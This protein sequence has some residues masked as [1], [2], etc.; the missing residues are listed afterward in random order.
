MRAL[1]PPMPCLIL[2][3]SVAA[4]A[5]PDAAAR[6]A[7]L[8]ERYSA[9]L[10]IVDHETD[11]KIYIPQIEPAS[12]LVISGC[13][14]R[15]EIT[16]YSNESEP[17]LASWADIDL[18]SVEVAV[19]DTGLRYLFY[20]DGF[21]DSTIAEQDVIMF[22]TLDDK[23]IPITICIPD[24]LAPDASE[25]PW[26]WPMA[27]SEK[28]TILYAVKHDATDVRIQNLSHSL[29]DYQQTYCVSSS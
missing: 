9:T 26:D 28:S 7:A 4:D 27:P 6:I 18:E 22:T 11:W 21:F 5:Q 19:H 24:M 16:I 17:Y 10:P 23:G 3:Q 20:P 2:L 12:S 14:A 29:F 13:K 15:V 1:L 8:A 25:N